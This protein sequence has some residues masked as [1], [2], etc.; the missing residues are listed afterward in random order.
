MAGQVLAVHRRVY[1]G[2]TDKKR[3]TGPIPVRH[4]TVERIKRIIKGGDDLRALMKLRPYYKREVLP[5]LKRFAKRRGIS[6]KNRVDF[7]IGQSE[8][9]MYI[10][11]LQNRTALVD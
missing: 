7:Y 9:F 8:G 3:G 10:N 5:E 6:S 2:G 4:S 1:Y 11:Y